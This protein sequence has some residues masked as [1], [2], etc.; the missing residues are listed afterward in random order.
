LF[1]NVLTYLLASVETLWPSSKALDWE[2]V[3]AP[4]LLCKTKGKFLVH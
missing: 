3:L 2:L 4:V 1:I